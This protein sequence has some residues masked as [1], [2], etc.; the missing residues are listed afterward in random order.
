MY[1]IDTHTHLYDEQFEPDRSEVIVSAIA[2]GVKKMYL[3]NCDQHTI[4]GM[5]AL[6]TQFPEHCIPMM[7]VHP[8]YIKADYKTELSI[9]A[10]WLAQRKFAAIGEIGLDY[11]WD[12]TFI[13]E[14]K[15]AF[16]E[17]IEWAISYNLPVVIHTRDS[18]QDTVDIVASYAAQGLRGVFHCFTGSL[19][20]AKQIT[21]MGFYLGIGGV[22]TFKKAGIQ[23][24]VQQIDMQYLVL[25][26]D[27]PYLTPHPFRG[28]RN[29]SL[30]LPLI[31]QQ[32]AD[33]KG[34]PI[35]AVARQTTINAQNLFAVQ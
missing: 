19:E 31:A 23:E 26:T 22:L 8:C 32:L 5:L 3:P 33:L 12:K 24:V 29:Q 20:M 34:I 27:A 15:S 4:P 18:M 10:N 13:N 21:G 11:Y 1:W 7:G 35:A 17:Q 30:Y 25:E 16:R 28:K 2:A 6:E 9:A 14:Q